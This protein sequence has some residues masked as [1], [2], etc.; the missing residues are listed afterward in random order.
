MKK[1][2]LRYLVT[3]VLAVGT[4]YVSYLLLLHIFT[5]SP[6]KAISYVCGMIVAFVLNRYWTFESTNKAHKDAVKFTILYM[7]SL[8]TNVLINKVALMIFPEYVSFAF[9]VATGTTVVM[10]YV[11]QKFFVFTHKK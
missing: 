7:T 9:L 5:H 2:L 10:N 1:E 6:A 4:D 11:G 3:G 8:A